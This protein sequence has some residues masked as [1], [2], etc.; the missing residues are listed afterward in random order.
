M[1]QNPNSNNDKAMSL[2]ST[3]MLQGWVMTDESCSV[4]DCVVPIMRSKDKTIRFCVI[5]DKVPT[6]SPRQTAAAPAATET[7]FKSSPK[8]TQQQDESNS[9]EVTVES[10][11][12]QKKLQ[13]FREQREQSSKASQL[14]G[15]K[16]LQQWTLLNEICPSPSCYAV[17]LMRNPTT[18]HM[19]C[20]ICE[21]SYA[22]ISEAERTDVQP[23]VTEK[24]VAHP[25]PPPAQETQT[26]KRMKNKTTSADNDAS[27]GSMYPS[28]SAKPSS[29]VQQFTVDATVQALTE[30]LHQL[31]EKMCAYDHPS[32][33]KGYF[34]AIQSCAA[35][36]QACIEASEAYKSV[37]RS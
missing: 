13:S 37:T 29:S 1:L 4:Q 32:E 10:D 8:L 17:P 6:C 23:T 3:C 18:K 34:E 27:L 28:N 9:I 35:A 36:I 15:Q 7:A 5:H 26:F 31:T 16:L 33:L 22:T 24:T 30:K 19:Y 14:I 2:L 20:V 12:D 21:N 25:P 11:L